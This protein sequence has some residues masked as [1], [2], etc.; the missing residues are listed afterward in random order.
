MGDGP[1]HATGYAQEVAPAKRVHV[2]LPRQRV[3][4]KY[5]VAG[6]CRTIVRDAQEW[7]GW[8]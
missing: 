7:I 3:R 4:E 1:G 2:Q 6:I 5:L 8:F